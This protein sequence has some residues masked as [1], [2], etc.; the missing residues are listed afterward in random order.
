MFLADKG[1][2][3]KDFESS[4]VILRDDRNMHMIAQVTFRAVR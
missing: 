4:A 3:I 2:I 1:F